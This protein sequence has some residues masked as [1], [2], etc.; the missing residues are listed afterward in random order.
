MNKYRRDR[1]RSIVAELNKLSNQIESIKTIEEF[2]LENTPDN[3]RYSA[4]AESKE[5]AID[6]MDDALD[7][8]D[9]AI[10]SISSCIEKLEE[11]IAT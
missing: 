10:E 5:E 11:A 3:L 2:K 8:L 6:S 1:L 9:D 7:E 4:A